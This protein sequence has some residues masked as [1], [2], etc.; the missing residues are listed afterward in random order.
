MRDRAGGTT[1]QGLHGS[2]TLTKRQR[3]SVERYKGVGKAWGHWRGTM[4][5][6]EKTVRKRR[7][8]SPVRDRKPGPKHPCSTVLSLDQEA[9]IVAFRRHTLLLLDACLYALQ[10]MMPRLRRSLLHRCL[11][12]HGISRLPEVEGNKPAKEKFHHYPVGFF[13]LDIA[14]LRRA[15]GKLYLF[16]ALDRTSRF[17]FVQLLDCADMD[18]AS[19][20]LEALIEAVSYCIASTPCSLTT[21]CEFADLPKNRNG[22]T[23]RFL[24]HPFNRVCHLWQKRPVLTGAAGARILEL[25]CASLK[26]DDQDRYIAS[27]TVPVLVPA[28]IGSQ[29]R[30]Y[31][32]PLLCSWSEMQD[33]D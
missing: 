31:R 9:V 8:R 16:V 1:D 14:E 2:A 19:G 25:L 26:T 5:S 11:E 10:V 33:L 4:E 6:R 29:E 24:A 15:E 12:R 18:A 3:R 28:T 23:A 27:L 32:S 22:P 7:Q 17:T 13:H 21:A 30:G 20:F